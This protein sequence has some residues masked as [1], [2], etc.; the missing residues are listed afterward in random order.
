MNHAQ[1]PSLAFPHL[2]KVELPDVTR[3]RFKRQ[4]SKAIE[5]VEEAVRGEI[6]RSDRLKQMPKG[7]S[8]A[9]A[10]GSRGIAKIDLV[11]RATVQCLREM[12]HSPFVVPAMGS[13]GGGTAEGQKE[14]LA[15][16]GMTEESLGA[17]IRSSMEV[18]DYGE[19]PDGAR[20]KFDKIAA[21]ADGIVVIN[22]I[23]SHTT[24]DRPIESGL[25]K[26]VAVGLGKAEGARAV[27]RTG[28]D[29]FLRTLPNLAAIALDKAPVALGIALVENAQKQLHIIEGVAPSD[30]FASDERLLKLAKSFIPRL[31]FEQLDALAVEQIGKDISGAGMDF[32]VTGRADLRSM[33]NPAPFIARIAVLGLTKGTGGNG[34]GVGLA[35]FTTLSVMERIDIQQI[36][37][38]SLTSTMVEK[39]RIPIV[40]RNDKDALRALVSTSWSKDDRSTRFCQIRSTLHLDEVLISASLLEEARQSPLYGGEEDVGPL[41]FDSEGQLTSRAYVAG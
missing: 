37:M 13:H 33:P 23:K 5:N 1:F 26:M 8:I 6:Q 16:L 36:Y 12:G 18:V 19:T 10:V 38:N 21:E 7:A 17:E 2:D 27:H 20:C 39:S 28:P 41:A 9:V 22:R 25:V 40:L 34:L 14:V 24:F 30:F 3:V 32:A 29:A 15:K 4:A 31:P 11:A 35:D